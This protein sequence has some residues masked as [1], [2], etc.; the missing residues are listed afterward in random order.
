VTVTSLPRQAAD[1]VVEPHWAIGTKDRLVGIGI[2]EQFHL[3]AL[4]TALGLAGIIAISIAAF[5]FSHRTL[6]P[7]G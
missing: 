5:L 4:T 2:E 6:P 1:L 7:T 3:R